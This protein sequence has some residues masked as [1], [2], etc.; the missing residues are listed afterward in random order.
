MKKIKGLALTL[1]LLIFMNVQVSASPNNNR[2][3]L[4]YKQPAK[5]WMESSPLGNG[6]IGAMVYGGVETETVALNEVTMWSGERDKFQERLCGKDILNDIRQLFFAGDYSKGNRIASEYL[7]GTPHSFGSHVPLGDMKINFKYPQGN[8]SDYKRELNLENAINTVTFKVGN[9][10][11]TREYFCSNP[12]EAL[13]IK[14]S[15]SKAKALNLN[16]SF[17]L[18]RESEMRTTNNGLEFSG[19]VSFPKQ[20]PGGVNFLGKVGVTIKDGK[21]TTKDGKIEITDATSIVIAFDVRTDYSNPRYK[22]DCV[23]TVDNV[24]AQ[25]YDKVKQNHIEDYSNLYKRVDLFLGNSETDILPT[26][27]R[28]KKVKDGANDVGLDAL[29]FNYARYLLIAASREN[30]PLP[31]NLQGIWNDNLAC[32][33]GWTNDYHLDINTQQNYWLSNIGNLAE[34]NKPLFNYI[35]DLS[36]EGQRTAKNV[37]GA[38][39]WTAHT[40]AN[41]WGYTSPGAGP[42]WGLF[43]MASAWIASHLWTH[44]NYTLDKDFLKDKAYPILKSNAEFLLDYMV[45]NPNNGYLMTGPSTSPENSFIYK[46]EELSLSMM[47]TADRVLAFEALTSCIEI[48]EILGVDKEFR[49]SLK[50]ALAKLPPLKIGKN[51]GVQE[52]FEDFDEAQPNHRHTSHLLALY[53]FSQ[54]SPVKTPVLAEAARKTM[55]LRLAAEGWEDVEW[56]RA[57]MI[58][59]Y[60]RLLDAEKAYESVVLL[61]RNFS[62]ENLLTISP[63]GIAG[64]PYDI[65]IF[66]GNEAGGAG[67]AEMLLQ[68]HEGY[69]QFLPA[70]P[71]EW[72]TGSFKGLHTQGGAE[73]DL[74]WANGE[75]TEAKLKAISANT[76]KLKVPQRTKKAQFSKNGKAFNLTPDANGFVEVTLSANDFIELK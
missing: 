64:A 74:K 71:K 13:I 37:Y 9:V 41:V 4:W 63:E 67:I 22:E 54:I 7:S 2:H 69:I 8:I 51:G 62:R 10:K 40:V 12:D 15:A 29:F 57:N 18:L 48:S 33:M 39:G 72:N 31:A 50:N 17:D 14:L 55:E 73:V 6:R 34:C 59:N 25:N 75:V 16:L 1:L 49:D 70:L 5:V 45:V 24:L 58:S 56:S 68:S 30:S 32:N 3:R 43:P 53:P 36:I 27:I 47:P 35:K 20:G 23:K 11:Y 19:Q 28:W 46:G 60:A 52:W 44:Y 66:D 38:R 76:F 65:F 61:E 42:N 26:D 21:V